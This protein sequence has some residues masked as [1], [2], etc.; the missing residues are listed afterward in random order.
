V[1]EIDIN[2]KVER[3]PKKLVLCTCELIYSYVR[4]SI[5]SLIFLAAR[6]KEF[7]KISPTCDDAAVKAKAFPK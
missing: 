5:A 7:D 6:P 1:K 2:N 3:G 4:T